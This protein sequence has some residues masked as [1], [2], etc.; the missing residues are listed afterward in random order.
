[1]RA[2]DWPTRDHVV[3]R[4]DA[5]FSARG[6]VHVNDH[7][8]VRSLADFSTITCEQRDSSFPTME[9]RVC[10][11]NWLI[12]ENPLSNILHDYILSIQD[13][14]L[15]LVII[16][17]LHKTFKTKK[18]DLVASLTESTLVTHRKSQV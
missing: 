13:F 7:E 8:D 1:M 6:S 9:T 15:L 18:I 4:R 14:K 3:A 16:L 11:K 5:Q 2:S 12:D 10:S 17:M